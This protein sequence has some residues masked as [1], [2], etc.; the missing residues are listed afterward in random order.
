MG[1]WSVLLRREQGAGHQPPP[2]QH[3][4]PGAKKKKN[5]IKFKINRL[6][7]QNW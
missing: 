6:Y 4:A 3:K 5:S 2:L 1:G 7:E